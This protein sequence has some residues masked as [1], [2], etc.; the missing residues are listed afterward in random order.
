MA[1][2]ENGK[3][4]LLSIS[5]DVVKVNY[6][7][8][9]LIRFSSLFFAVLLLPLFISFSLSLFYVSPS[10]SHL[11]LKKDISKRDLP[12]TLVHL[13]NNIPTGDFQNAH[14]SGYLVSQIMKINIRVS[15]SIHALKTTG[16]DV[17]CMSDER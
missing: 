5:K 9:R 12:R 14:K 3:F 4:C 15:P 11:S 16:D 2:L 6:Y 8:S 1:T 10:L 7:H 13:K 17:S